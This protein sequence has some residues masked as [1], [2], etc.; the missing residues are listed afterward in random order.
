MKNKV[1]ARTVFGLI[2][3]FAGVGLLVFV[4]ILGY[5]MF[6]AYTIEECLNQK[7][8]L[9]K[10]TEFAVGFLVKALA[11]LLMTAVGSVIAG[12]GIDM[13]FMLPVKDKKQNKQ[14]E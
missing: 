12:K 6:A 4:F 11:L 1:S 9:Q 7:N 5:N 8:I 10:L 2:V 3:V 13:L 14:K